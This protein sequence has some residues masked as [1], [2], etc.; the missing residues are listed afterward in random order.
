[1]EDLYWIF[2]YGF[3]GSRLFDL[4]NFMICV[5]LVLLG[6]R[7]LHVPAIIQLVLVLHCLLPFFLN[8]VLF[9]YGYMPDQ[10]KYWNWFNQIRSG[11]LPL[12]DAITGGNTQQAAVFFALMPFPAA[13]AP[14]S[15]GFFNSFL[16]VFTFFWLYSKKVFTR[17][18]M[19]FFL[20]YPSMA[21][22]SALSLRETL[23][24]VFMIVA[25]Q[26]AREGRWLSMGLVLVP[27]Y[28]VKFQNFYILAP[29]LALY[30]VF[31][32]RR[33]GL[34]IGKGAATAVIGFCSLLASAP[35]ALPLVNKFRVAMF[36][37]DGG[38]PDDIQLISSSL[39]FVVQGMTSSFYFLIKP[40][41]WE[42]T[43]ALQLIQSIENI[44][45]FGLLI[46]ITRIAWKNAPKKLIFWLLLML[47]SMSV[48]GLVVVNFGTAVRYRYPFV[49]IFVLFVCADCQI[50][51]ALP[52]FVFG[53]K[54]L[55][56][57]KPKLA[58]SQ[59]QDI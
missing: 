47:F 43:N 33:T 49:V 55:S 54:G 29:I 10:F 36:V 58:H 4:P 1:M 9:D 8:G 13:V 51:R 53:N 15:L 20:L 34:S 18:S 7:K 23:I 28:L 11:Q 41:P 24:M 42:I 50:H 21:L 32:I 48:Y 30:L 39:D 59:H 46:I 38:H 12:T 31:G 44:I 45:V 16:Y 2:N 5:V 57:P 17:F 22:Y 27:L 40:L 52:N 25:V 6:S 14:L 37:E 35:V 56:K 19:W 26:F 3:L